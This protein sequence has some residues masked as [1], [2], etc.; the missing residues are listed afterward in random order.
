MA[1]WVKNLTSNHEDVGSIPGFDPWVR[2]QRCQELQCRLQTRLRTG[3]AVAVAQGSSCSS[4]LTLS[5]GTSICC[6]FSR[7]KK[8]KK[9]ELTIQ[10]IGTIN[11]NLREKN[12]ST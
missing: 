6:R 8:K 3:V 5:L 9:H 7:K 11:T 2:I 1:R 12:N 4:N 10:Q